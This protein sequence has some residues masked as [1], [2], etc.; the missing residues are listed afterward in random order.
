MKRGHKFRRPPH[1][2]PR[3]AAPGQVKI[4][5]RLK[6]KLK[7]PKPANPVPKAQTDFRAEIG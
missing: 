2:D 1:L 6:F 5:R 3:I 4:R 7:A